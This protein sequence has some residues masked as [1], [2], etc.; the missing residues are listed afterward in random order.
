MTSLSAC[1]GVIQPPG[2]LPSCF[3]MASVASAIRARSSA[4][5]RM[6]GFSELL[7]PCPMISSCLRL[8]SAAMIW[9]CV[10]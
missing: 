8:P 2:A 9:G 1:S 4:S 5:G 10:S 3:T 6:P 7:R